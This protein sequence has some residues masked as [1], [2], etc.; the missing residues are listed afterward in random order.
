MRAM[1]LA[2]ALAWPLIGPLAAAAG[3]LTAGRT[4]PAGTLI[5]SGDLIPDPGSNPAAAE[6]L[7]GLE[8]RVTIYAGRP[9]SPAQ[10]Q[11]PRLIARN[12]IAPL[13][14]QSGALR[15]ETSGRA[16]AEGGAGA[17]IPVLNIGSRQTVSAE[18][19]ADGTLIISR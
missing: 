2:A 11:E 10:L 18:I 4:L 5:A 19:A 17:V 16:L 6:A 12:Q 3:D 7:V 15:I 14:F 8:T 13:I 9:V 1:I